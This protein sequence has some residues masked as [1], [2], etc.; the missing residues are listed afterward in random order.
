LLIQILLYGDSI[1]TNESR[2]F[3]TWMLA[4]VVVQSLALRP[5]F[6]HRFAIALFLI[7]ICMLP[8]L[9]VSE[10]DADRFRL[11]RSVGFSNANDLGAFFG[12][13]CLYFIIAAIENRQVLTRF[14]C[15]LG[16]IGSLYVVG[17]TVSR[18]PLFAIAVA[19]VVGGRRFLKRGFIPLL[20]LVLLAWVAYLSGLF[21]QALASYQNRFGQETGR[22]QVWPLALE[23]FWD[24]PWFGVG[25]SNVATDVPGRKPVTPHNGFLHVGLSSG[26]VPLLFFVAY[27]WRSGRAALAKARQPSR[28]ARF[29]IPLWLY[30]FL[31]TFQLGV[32]FMAP[33]SIVILGVAM[34]RGSGPRRE[35]A[36]G[37]R[38]HRRPLVMQPN[39]FGHNLPYRHR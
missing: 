8:Y 16:A 31:I 2:N 10:S 29:Q 38:R 36:S 18:G 23:R 34:S 1:L 3:V 22:L 14:A 5:G 26:L 37:L 25:V 24:S 13:F 32:A 20:V 11:D 21:D 9:Q 4:L 6:L 39:A 15:G 35:S 12:F 28:D 30:A 27:W 17:L 19:A 33:W 7:G